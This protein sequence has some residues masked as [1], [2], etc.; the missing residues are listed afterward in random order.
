ML[1]VLEHS[2]K[3]KR[4]KQFCNLHNINKVSY[5]YVWGTDGT[6]DTEGFMSEVSEGRV[7]SEKFNMVSPR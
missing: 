5:L 1:S 4:L 6:K 2:N 3:G 7:K